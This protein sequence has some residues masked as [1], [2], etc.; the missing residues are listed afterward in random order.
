VLIARLRARE[1]SRLDRTGHVYLDY[2]GSALYPAS[3]VRRHARLMIDRVLG[4]PHSESGPSRAS[5]AAID[6]ARRLTLEL[7][8]ADPAVYD[9][10]FTANASGAIRLLAEAFPFAAGSRLVLTADNHN[11]VNG[12]RVAAGRRGAAV[13][14]VPLDEELR[15]ADP[16]SWLRSPKAAS[17]FA[18]PAQSNFSCVRHPLAWAAD[19]QRQGYRV[20]VDAAA[21]AASSPLSLADVPAD[22]VAVSFYKLFGYPTGVGALIARRDALAFLRRGYFGGGTV[23]FASVQNSLAVA[24]PGAE[25][26]EDGTPNFLAMPAVCDGLRWLRRLNMRAVDCHVSRLTS[27][28][29]E[30]LGRLKDAVEIYGPTCMDGRGGTVAF[31]VRRN[32]AWLP[33]EAVEAGARRRGIAIRGGCFCNPGAAERAFGFSPAVAR[34]CLRGGFSL[35]SFRACMGNRPVGALRA[36]IGVPTTVADVDRLI[37]FVESLA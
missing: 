28:L 5:T 20:L 19:A 32:G 25:A 15:A 33:Y 27:R 23:Q 18:F 9:V 37:E 26:F 17:L 1:F 2:T 21:Y 4:N 30:R 29:I 10:V 13:V 36:S 22:F 12:L 14:Y 16:G 6:T 34:A 31:N 24:R 11:S 35:T 8:D 3:L 7:F